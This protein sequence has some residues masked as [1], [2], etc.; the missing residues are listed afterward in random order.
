[1]VAKEALTNAALD[2][3]LHSRRHATFTCWY[4]GIFFLFG[5]LLPF[6]LT[7]LLNTF[8]P[9]EYC[10]LVAAA[11][12]AVTMVFEV[13]NDKNARSVFIFVFIILAVVAAFSILSVVLYFV[14]LQTA[15]PAAPH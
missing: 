11:F 8:S 3:G 14:H 13:E 9:W 2:S 5:M 6:L 15:T 12:F 1:M 7:L 4:V 10:E